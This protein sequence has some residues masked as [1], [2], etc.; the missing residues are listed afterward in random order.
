MNGGSMK[1]IQDDPYSI[2]PLSGDRALE[3][4]HLFC[5]MG[6]GCAVKHLR[7]NYYVEI[8]VRLVGDPAYRQEAR[9]MEV[10]RRGGYEVLQTGRTLR[11]A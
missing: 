9:I 1:G 7:G 5:A 10:A 11:I 8:P 3:I 6:Y 4:F 2:K